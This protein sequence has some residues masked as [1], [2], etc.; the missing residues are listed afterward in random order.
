MTMQKKKKK[1]KKKCC[2]AHRVLMCALSTVKSERMNLRRLTH[3][4]FE[5][6]EFR[7]WCRMRSHTHTPLLTCIQLDGTSKG[8][9]VINVSRSINV[10]V[11]YVGV[12]EKIDD[13]QAFDPRRFVEAIL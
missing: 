9:C 4:L 13:L 6:L 8:G 10:P 5:P 7:S 2:P 3:Q 12:G 11:K 1:K